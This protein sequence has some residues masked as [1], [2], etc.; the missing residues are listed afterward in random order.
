MIFVFT[1]LILFVAMLALVPIWLDEEMRENYKFWA[2]VVA[3]I[4]IPWLIM[5]YIK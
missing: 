1:L 5:E 2:I 3:A 4:S